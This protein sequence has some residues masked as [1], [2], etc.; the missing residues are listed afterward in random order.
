M[1]PQQ[2]RR[3]ERE[4]SA[5]FESLTSE[6]GRPERRDAMRLYMTGLLLE[7]ERKS[8]EPMAARLVGEPGEVQAMRQRLQ[9]CVTVSTWAEKELFRR[10]AVK[11]EAEMPG[12]EALVIDDTGFAKK[13]EHSVGVARQYSGTLGRVDNCQVATSLHLAGEAGSACIGFRLYLPEEWANDRK[14]RRKA[15]VPEDIEFTPKW[16]MALSLVDDALAAGV[17]SHVVLADAAYG[18]INEFRN[19]ITERGLPY[20]LAVKGATVVYPPGTKLSLPRKATHVGRPRHIARAEEEPIS[21]G[22]LAKTLS[23]R[24]VSWRE[25]SRGRQSSRFAAVRVRTAHRHAVGRAPSP[26]QW[27]LCEWPGDEEAPCKFYLSTLPAATAVRDLVRLAKLR[28][29]IERDYQ[30][31]KGELGLDHYEGRN[32]LGFHHHAA[33]CAAAHA[34]LALRR[35]LFPPEQGAVDAPDGPPP[36][37]ARPAGAATSLPAVPSTRGAHASRPRA[38]AHVIE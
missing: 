22:A 6:M 9:Q 15:G 16:Q 1:T 3:L 35:A 10:I 20:M 24:H 8:I 34:F 21:I 27:L 32:W 26:E 5:Y 38:L 13:G 18:D 28:W 23:F 33:L 19:A 11:V 29:R 25:G 30:E 37:A 2:L 17:R 4:L 31:M 36:P 12:V 7:G 14:R